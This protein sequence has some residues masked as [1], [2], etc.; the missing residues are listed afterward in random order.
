[1]GRAERVPCRNEEMLKSVLGRIT[2]A[3]SDYESTQA[4]YNYKADC[5]EG[6]QWTYEMD[7]WCIIVSSNSYY[8]VG[9]CSPLPPLPSDPVVE[10]LLP[11]LWSTAHVWHQVQN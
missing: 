2:Q 6:E 11:R 9:D 3:K 5:I 4:L 7:H 10:S 8:A 1:M